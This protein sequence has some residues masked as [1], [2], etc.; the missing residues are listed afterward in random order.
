MASDGSVAL[1]TSLGAANISA[2]VIGYAPS[3][4]S[5]SVPAPAPRPI[6]RPGKPRSVTVKSRHRAV[7]T[8]WKAPRRSGGAALTGYRV[9][10]LTSAKRGASV[11]G[12]CSTAP[13]VRSCT[14][15]GL[16][17]GHKYWMSVSVANSGGATWAARKKVRVR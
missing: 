17:K 16:K 9:E 14:I 12:S 3:S 8:R 2:T 13:T 7:T 10:A 6:T 11:A 5:F 1:G 4:S 15:K